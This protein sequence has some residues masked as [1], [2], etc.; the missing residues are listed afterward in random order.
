MRS[1]S[2][3]S[4]SSSSSFFAPTQPLDSLNHR[5]FMNEALIHRLGLPSLSSHTSSS[6]ATC[7]GDV[8]ASRNSFD[9][10]IWALFALPSSISFPRSLLYYLI[11]RL[12]LLL[13]SAFPMR[14]LRRDDLI[15]LPLL[16]SFLR[17]TCSDNEASSPAS[18][19]DLRERR[20]RNVR[21]VI[22]FIANLAHSRG[23]GICL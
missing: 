18:P 23:G 13:S 17:G 16:R 20:V 3:S 10:S 9:Y 2:E 21:S 22:T 5:I 15:V 12:L 4:P 14:P 6:R 11:V 1:K 7:C 19:N 8:L